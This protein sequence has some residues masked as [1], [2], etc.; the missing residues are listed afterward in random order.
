MKLRR[1]A[2]W[3]LLLGIGVALVGLLTPIVYLRIVMHGGSSGIIGGMDGPTY[4]FIL[5][6][7]YDGWP[8]ALIL[9]GIS[10]VIS[11]GFCLLLSRTVS[12]HCNIKTSAISLG[13]SGTGALG[14][15]C[16]LWWVT[17]AAFGEA[18]KHPV[19]YPVSIALGMLCFLAFILL[20]G[21]YFMVRRKNWSVIGVIIDVLTSILYLPSF[22][23]IISY[24]HAAFGRIF[25]H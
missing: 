9:L 17:L 6:R 1:Y 3:T 25:G 24:I 7:L 14:V 13:L 16:V 12:T 20:V 23:M 15:Y 22:F 8:I 11:S 21:L 2:L 18:S 19:V 4:W 10:V 5:S